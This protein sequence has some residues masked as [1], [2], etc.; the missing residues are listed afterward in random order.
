MTCSG[1]PFT[2]ETGDKLTLR[3]ARWGSGPTDLVFVHGAGL[4][5]QTYWP[6]LRAISDLA[7]IHGFNSRGHGGSDVPRVMSPYDEPYED[8]VQ[9]VARS[10]RAPVIMAGHSF[11]AFLTLKMAAEHPDLVKGII[12]LDPLITFAPHEMWQAK[13]MDMD[14]ERVARTRRKPESWTD[15]TAAEAWVRARSSFQRW[16][17]EALD[18]YL[19]TCLR[20]TVN[21]VSLCCPPWFE[22]LLYLHRPFLDFWPW[23]D[24]IAAP[25]A[26]LYG[27]ASE[28]AR[29]A[30]IEHAARILPRA[31]VMQLPG[32]HLF[33]QEYPRET[34]QALREA[35]TAIG[36]DQ[37]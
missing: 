7:V 32:G 31:T 27:E 14:A 18:L 5:A 35:L 10:L 26:L 20:E 4:S 9:F 24:R 23:I 3:C 11:G 6:A 16:D 30:A 21:G 12:L 29:R 17:S 15:R 22:A 8:L 33:A 34:G 25:A 13:V 37:R 36:Q 19:T 1:T 2:I 28:V